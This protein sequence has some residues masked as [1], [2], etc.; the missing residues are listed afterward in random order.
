MLTPSFASWC[1]NTRL[2]EELV[3]VSIGSFVQVHIRATCSDLV[4]IDLQAA[5]Q[6]SIHTLHLPGA[7]LQDDLVKMKVFV[8]QG[9]SCFSGATFDCTSS[10]ENWQMV[11]KEEGQRVCPGRNPDTMIFHRVHMAIEEVC[12]SFEPA[13]KHFILADTEEQEH[14]RT[15]VFA[16]FT[17]RFE[18][19]GACHWTPTT[20]VWDILD[21][22]GGESGWVIYHNNQK[23]RHQRVSVH[24]GD[25][26]ACYERGEYSLDFCQAWA[27][28]GEWT[29]RV[30]FP[31]P[32]GPWPRHGHAGALLQN[33]YQC[34]SPRIVAWARA[35]FEQG[36]LPSLLMMPG[37]AP[38]FSLPGDRMRGWKDLL[39]RLQLKGAAA[40]LGTAGNRQCGPVWV[41]ALLQEQPLTSGCYPVFLKGK[42]YLCS[43]AGNS[44]TLLGSRA[45]PCPNG[46]LEL[47]W[48][49]DRMGVTCLKQNF[50]AQEAADLYQAVHLHTMEDLGENG[51]Y[52]KVVSQL[53]LRIL[54]YEYPLEAIL[55]IYYLS[56]T[57]YLPAKFPHDQWNE[58]VRWHGDTKLAA[59][60]QNEAELADAKIILSKLENVMVEAE[61][62]H[63]VVVW[64][65]TQNCPTTIPA[66]SYPLQLIVVP[67]EEIQRR[68]P[69][70]L[71]VEATGLGGRDL[72]YP[73]PWDI[74][75][76]SDKEG[77]SIYLPWRKLV[78]VP[79]I[80]GGTETAQA[81]ALGRSKAAHEFLVLHYFGLDSA[82]H[83]DALL[84]DVLPAVRFPGASA[85]RAIALEMFGAS[86]IALSHRRMPH[87]LWTD[88]MNLVWNLLMGGRMGR[89][90][91][92]PDTLVFDQ[93]IDLR[94][95]S[96]GS[97]AGLS[98]LHL[99][100]KMPNVATNGKLGAIAC[101][102]Q[103]IVTP[104]TDHTLHLLHY[105]A[106]QL[107]V[108]K[109]GGHQLDQLQIR[110]TYV[111]T[112]GPAYK[113]HFGSKEHNY[114]HWLSLNHTAGWWDLA[115]FLFMN[116]EAAS[117]AKRDA[118]P[119]RLLSWLSFRL[120]PAVEKLLE[121]TMLYLST[122]DEVKDSELLEL[123]RMHL[124][125]DTPFVSAEA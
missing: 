106:D 93:R 40:M 42:N 85:P 48:T 125:V 74:S 83:W 65:S 86:H 31:V 56:A 124:E 87:V 50:D 41:S 29:S 123:G 2:R 90:T 24:Q 64:S 97:F 54:T 72:L 82:K 76:R 94:G 16:I 119:L 116:P 84:F 67:G 96:A 102:P 120:E 99:L 37:I 73:I 44:G 88:S 53:A 78:D 33:N 25:F 38:V 121:A 79:G 113:E 26:F 32:K 45:L 12:P 114:S 19:F 103:L 122:V 6:R 47:M 36:A 60:I 49:L 1:D 58:A 108:W 68:L 80:F 43:R 35:A 66:D 27:L 101:P 115:R 111:S 14:T 117:S 69:E 18:F 15:V 118:T 3:E 10:F 23:L 5:L 62:R 89:Y 104:P 30:L 105:E 100:W 61:S 98:T 17:S 22:C 91:G 4:R 28:I 51:P 95:F 11:L 59:T 71:H 34:R 39:P 75:I 112:E 81:T 107:C 9:V 20:R 110:Y 55:A 8:P 92:S 109:P 7:S 13:V 63:G 57:G 70:T 21:L 46:L 52:P 77:Q